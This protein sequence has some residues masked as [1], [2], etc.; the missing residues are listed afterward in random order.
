[1]DVTRKETTKS[2][3]RMSYTIFAYS[4]WKLEKINKTYQDLIH[5]TPMFHHRKQTLS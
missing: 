5:K 3:A 2:L 1:M 4:A